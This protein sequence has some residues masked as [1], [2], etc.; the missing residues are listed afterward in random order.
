MQNYYALILGTLL[1]T[2]F[3]LGNNFALLFLINLIFSLN[4][5]TNSI[6]ARG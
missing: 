1:L 3:N 2:L 6:K 5:S 4:F